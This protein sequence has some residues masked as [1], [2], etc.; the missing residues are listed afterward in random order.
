M[1]AIRSIMLAVYVVA[2]I[3]QAYAQSF[4]EIEPNSTCGSAQ[5]LPSAILPIQVHGFKTQP[6]GDAVDFYKFSATPGTQLRAT[7]DG[8]PFSPNPLTAFGVG[9]F[10]PFCPAFPSVS[11]FT[12]SS[13]AQI[14]FTVPPDGVSIIGVTACCDTNFS[15][16]GTIEGAYVLSVE[17]VAPPPPTVVKVQ[18]YGATY[19][20][21]S[22]RWWQ[23]VLAIPAAINPNLDT[24]GANCAQGQYDDVWFL[25]GAFGGIVERTCTIPAGKPIFF[26]LINTIAFKPSGKETLLN[27]RRQSAA[28]IDNVAGL[29]CTMDGVTCFQDRSSFRVKSPS[30]TVIAPANGLVPPGKLSVPGNTD[31]IVSD[32]YWLLLDPPAPGPHTIKFKATTNDFSLDVTYNLTIQ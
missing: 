6:F 7:L 28:F 5:L 26:P 8:D 19:G 17:A 14:E 20:E 25:A 16:S 12:I 1:N 31:P 24:T 10:P 11:A 22:A 13:P 30:F 23:W 2:F 18:T 21:L 3:P 27:L 15:G 32:G 9:L 4:T 29:D